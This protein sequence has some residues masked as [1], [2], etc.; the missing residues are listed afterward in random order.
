MNGFRVYW[1]LGVWGSWPD[2]STP[3]LGYFLKGLGETE[4]VSGITRV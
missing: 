4:A 3:G 2:S 1:G